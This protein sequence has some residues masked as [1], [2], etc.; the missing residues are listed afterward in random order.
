[1]KKILWILILCALGL[2]VFVLGLYFQDLSAFFNKPKIIAKVNAVEITDVDLKREMAFLKVSENAGFGENTREDL[3]D[4]MINDTLVLQEAQRLGITAPEA[5]VNSRV[6]AAQAGYST[7][8][9]KKAL[10]ELG[11]NAERWHDLIQRQLLIETTVQ[12]VVEE[13][14]RVGED[15]I[16][17]YYWAHQ[18]DY[19]RPA[20]VHARQIVV[21][22]LEQ[23]QALRAKLKQG[24]DFK[25]LARTYSR[26]PERDLGGD[27]GW[28]AELDLPRAFSQVLF[29][30]PSGEISEP[31]STQY[32]FHLF[33]VDE[34]DAGGKIPPDE[35]KR[36]IADDLKMEKADQAFQAWIEDLRNKA[37]ITIK[38]VRGG[39]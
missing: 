36:K 10:K 13:S 14:V 39:E 29:H 38:D 6:A 23:A 1:M 33:K 15:E 5:L 12:K 35:A 37:K 28:V 32:G 3:L 24:A 8:E 20:R 19:V 9:S 4:R 18:A 17:S 22:T 21:E 27:L 25:E 34:T 26:G 2:V 30:L 7:E 16:D 31:V 11:I